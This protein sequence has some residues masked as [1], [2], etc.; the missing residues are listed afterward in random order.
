MKHTHLFEQ[1]IPEVGTSAFIEEFVNTNKIK[2]LESADVLLSIIVDELSE[3]TL[4]DGG[5]YPIEQKGYTIIHKPNYLTAFVFEVAIKLYK[6]AQTRN[7]KASLGFLINDLGIDSEM[8]DSYK[9]EMILHPYYIDLLKKYDLTIS[10][11]TRVFY[12]SN[13]RNRASRQILKNGIKR[14]LIKE[15]DTLLF[16]PDILDTNKEPNFSNYL[17]HKIT[18]KSSESMLIP[19]CRAIMAQKLL[20]TE[21]LGFKK[22]INFLTEHEFKCLGEFAKIYHLFG[23]K[24]NVVNV[25]FSPFELTEKKHQLYNNSQ[26]AN[27]AEVYFLKN[28]NNRFFVQIQKYY[29]IN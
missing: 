28:A 18:D 17:G 6:M 20:D 21:N 5:H 26:C 16:V 13:L 29:K 14:G 7:V 27:H 22:T 4:I 19:F 12:E 10:N 25:L 2:S 24:N 15:C 9:K 8:R 1:I 3:E 11:I 23:G